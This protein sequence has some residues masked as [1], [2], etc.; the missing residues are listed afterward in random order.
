MEVNEIK[1]MDD[2]KN[3]KKFIASNP[4]FSKPMYVYNIMCDCLESHYRDVLNKC[5]F[6]ISVN[7]NV[8][9]ITDRNG[10]EIPVSIREVRQAIPYIEGII[11]GS[12]YGNNP[13]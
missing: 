7:D 6:D 1:K 11:I 3:S 8:I 2:G 12:S 10:G 4:E 5:G 9:T 13:E